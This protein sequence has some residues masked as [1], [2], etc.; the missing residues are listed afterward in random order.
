MPI[1]DRFRRRPQWED[2]D[3]LVRASAVRQ[4]AADQAELIA[5]IAR[6]DEDPRVRRAA[7]KRLHDAAVLA[8][9]AQTDGDAAVQEAAFEGLRDHVIATQD[10]AAGESALAALSD[11]RDLVAIAREAR[12]APLRES[13]LGRLS[14]PK[15]L[16]SV[17]KSAHE[18]T[19][20]LA[21]LEALADRTLYVEVALKSEH[22]D[23]ALAALERV[24]DEEALR[25]VS[26]RAR[27]K[28]VGR[29][30][31][32]RLGALTR[33]PETSESPRLQDVAEEQ[34]R[35][36]RI[37]AEQQREAEQR[38]GAF[39]ARVA[40]CERVE[41][42][43]GPDIRVRPGA[44]RAGVDGALSRKRIPDPFARRAL[45]RGLRDLQDPPRGVARAARTVCRSSSK[46]CR[47]LEA[48]A[49]TDATPGPQ[50]VELERRYK[51]LEAGGSASEELRV[52]FSMA[53]AQIAGQ[54]AARREERAQLQRENL[55]RLDR[56]CER[57]EAQ[58][59]ATELTLRAAEQSH[60]A[61]RAA[62]ANLGSLP[63]KK[64][65]DHIQERLKSARAALFP[66]LQELREA[67]EWSRWANVAVQERLCQRTE[68]L[69]E[70]EDIEGVAQELR[71][72]DQ[73]WKQARQVPKDQAEALWARFRSAREQLRTRCDAHFARQS[74]EQAANLMRKQALCE[75]AEGLAASNDWVKTAQALK[76]LQEEWKSIGP[77]P[78]R[79]SDA[80]WR[81]FRRACD[82][83]FARRKTDLSQRKEQWAANLERKEA[84]CAQAESLVESNDWEDA[85]AALKRLQA[86][87]KT[88]GPVR[89]NRSEAVWRRFRGACD[90]FFE[91]Y[92]NRDELARAAN[93]A[94]HEGLCEELE[95][96]AG[97][98]GVPPD[99]L[100]TRVAEI[101]ARSRSAGAA[102]SADART[103]GER[104]EAARDRLIESYPESFRGTELDP[105]QNR[106][107]MERLC[108]RIEG[109][110][111]P[112]VPAASGTTDVET[113][114][115]RLREALATNT[116]GGRGAIEERW[117]TALEEVSSAR[118]AWKRL[119]PVPGEAGRALA[120]RFE[121]ACR[122]VTENRPRAMSP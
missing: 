77:V 33:D 109:L 84:L 56:L 62:L 115:D 107:R 16:V 46:L 54:R 72:I 105:E 31:R 103:L 3:P 116:L 39:E 120:E 100:A 75:Q 86:E 5:S 44:G 20:R 18:A 28:A 97:D 7:V 73:E 43:S 87:W 55:A 42:L 60:R 51:E 101:L 49:E 11:T 61:V 121:R 50:V 114:R 69:M 78:R 41:A 12:L 108:A 71:Q 98:D 113:L 48:L 66:K 65:H 68:A 63:S 91:R 70:S 106:A 13:A 38:D 93:R 22:K 83:F 40:L 117:K 102:P 67:D 94:V 32:V 85:A 53:L 79:Q 52:R 90:A 29:Q 47:E 89:K 76:L 74:E 17:A 2:P 35:Y 19:T 82:T 64:D 81:R 34:A 9:V 96:L 8:E 110:E 10:A 88:I 111:L 37:R 4:L 36:E 24:E 15:S 92:K 23:V 1:L 27:H 112:S 30:A 58:A 80:V 59:G 6:T 119:G 21:A 118:A 25:A 57:V 104:L 14:D 26:T 122:R 45:S 95:G 99:A